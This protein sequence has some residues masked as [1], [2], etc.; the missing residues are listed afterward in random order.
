MVLTAVSFTLGLNP[1]TNVQASG[2]R[3]LAL[4]PTM[5]LV[6]THGRPVFVHV[7]VVSREVSGGGDALHVVRMSRWVMSTCAGRAGV[8]EGRRV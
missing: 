1:Q 8:R 4:G 2:S 6:G 3:S 7:G 5:K